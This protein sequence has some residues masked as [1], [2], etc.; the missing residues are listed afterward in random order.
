[1]TVDNYERDN[2]LVNV[3]KLYYEFEYNQGM[4]AEKYGISRPFVSKLLAE[5][6]ERG[7][8]KI[9]VKD[10]LQA[11][12]R[13]EREIRQKYELRRVI[14]VPSEVGE[15][16]RMRVSMACGKYLNSIVKSG[17]IIGLGSGTTLNLTSR[18]LIKRE[19]LSHVKVVS[20]EGNFGNL[21][22]TAYHHETVRAFGI[23]LGA[24]PYSMPAP[25]ITTSVECKETLLREPII[26]KIREI[27]NRCNIAIFNVAAIST[28]RSL[29][30]VRQG[31][32]TE[33]YMK[34]IVNRGAVANL[35]FHFI[36]RDGKL[37]SQDME[38]RYMGMR[39]DL[40]PQKEYRICVCCGREKIEAVHTAL[41]GGYINVL[42]A[43]E[44]IA[45][46]ILN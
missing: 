32:V 3:A 10:P 44:N 35:M 18:C 20:L 22:H 45:E 36:D 29:G 1:M 6:K 13:L 21:L 4:I 12:N 8:V 28:G 9:Q 5:A 42:I 40:L 39:L 31:F 34:E 26:Q 16:A 11:E 2:L 14:I 27:Q 25:M 46:G 38:D 33:E 7:I 23:A 30:L 37:C 19:D 43:D 41:K 17:D 15:D 24:V